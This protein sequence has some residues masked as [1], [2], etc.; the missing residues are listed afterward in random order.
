MEVIRSSLLA[1]RAL[2]PVPFVYRLS[3]LTKRLPAITNGE[4]AI[5]GMDDRRGRKIDLALSWQASNL[6]CASEAMVSWA[7]IASERPDVII[8][9]VKKRA[10][11]FSWTKKT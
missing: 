3:T 2:R 11:S 4:T 9:V 6:S 8:G 10:A 5:A 7:T 1:P